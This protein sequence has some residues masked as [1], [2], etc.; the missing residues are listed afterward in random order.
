MSGFKFVVV[1]ILV[2]VTSQTL[3][4]QDIAK[5]PPFPEQSCLGASAGARNWPSYCND[6]QALHDKLVSRT[7]TAPVELKQL[8]SLLWEK[9]D[10]DM[11][12]FLALSLAERSPY[13]SSKARRIALM[14]EIEASLEQKDRVDDFIRVATD[15]IRAVEK[16]EVEPTVEYIKAG[17]DLLPGENNRHLLAL[18]GSSMIKLAQLN[19]LH[20][21]YDIALEALD[22]CEKAS[23]A[24]GNPLMPQRCYNLLSVFG[25][26]PEG[27]LAE[28]ATREERLTC[29][30]NLT[31][32]CNLFRKTGHGRYLPANTE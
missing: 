19:S 23:D 24:W 32:L 5:A 27:F 6:A 21:R 9:G 8:K 13:F 31:P 1:C 12:R 18:L 4:A 11:W 22:L 25:N 29:G 16:G 2:Q 15:T 20:A 10:Q 14:D 28:I 30:R 26:E 17:Q 7:R 3:R